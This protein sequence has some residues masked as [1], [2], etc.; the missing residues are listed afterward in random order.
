MARPLRVEFDGSIYHITFRGNAREDIFDDE[1]D[2]RLFP[3][4]LAK[5]VHRFY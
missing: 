1:Q 2:R 5:L 4:T 3:G